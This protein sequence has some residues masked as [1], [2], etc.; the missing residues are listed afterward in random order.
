MSTHEAQ[1]TDEGQTKHT[2]YPLFLVCLLP[3]IFLYIV[4]MVTLNIGARYFA[5]MLMPS[6]GSEFR[7]ILAYRMID[8]T[9][10]SSLRSCSTRQ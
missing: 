2:I 10:Q 4:P 7:P 6:L 3:I 9:S 8:L 1:T 5:M